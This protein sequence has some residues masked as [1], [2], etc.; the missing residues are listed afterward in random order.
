MRMNLSR[1]STFASVLFLSLAIAGCGGNG[2]TTGDGA[3]GG[4][5]GNGGN[6]AGGGMAG[7]GAGGG[8]SGGGAGGDG[9]SGG[10]AGGG[11]G[12]AGG[13]VPSEPA[14][15]ASSDAASGAA[16][17][18][19][20]FGSVTQSS[21]TDANGVTTDR[22]SASFTVDAQGV[23]RLTIDVAQEGMSPIEIAAAG[24]DD[25]ALS[26]FP[27]AIE[28]RTSAF[29]DP[30][31]VSN[32]EITYAR[33]KVEWSSSDTADY[34]AYGTWLNATG[35]FAD[36]VVDTASFGAFVDGPEIRSAATL[37]D[38]GT[39]TYT[40]PA[41]GMYAAEYGTD[42]DDPEGTV[43][44]GYF[45]GAT[46]LT[47]DFAANSIS[48]SVSRVFLVGVTVTPD[49][50]EDYF[51]GLS[52]YE[53]RLG[54]TPLVSDGTFT[55]ANATLYHPEVTYVSNAGSWGGRF[56]IKDDSAGNPRLVA[57]TAGGSATTSGGTTASFVGAFVGTTADFE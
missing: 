6:G 18:E 35:N 23:P 8:M 1:L 39:A 17:A 29:G 16:T 31:E 20:G 12:M 37:P 51:A 5:G 7:G 47:A 56:S 36:G 46:R 48:G 15:S 3:G 30:L 50:N 41:E 25:G 45:E 27:T 55:G 44:L 57:G 24:G 40:G 28:G 2:M 52:A 10:G 43:E 33:V 22:A 9:M 4:N 26:S 21:N 14:S 34:L 38:M 42:G 13:G 19:P 54:A 49:G 11:D 53:L 32:T